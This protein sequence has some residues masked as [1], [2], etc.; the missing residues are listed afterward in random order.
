MSVSMICLNV[1]PLYVV[2]YEKCHSEHV[3]YMFVFMLHTLCWC[4]L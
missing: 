4:L 1:Q 2:W 3:S